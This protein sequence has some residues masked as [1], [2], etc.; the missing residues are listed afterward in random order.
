MFPLHGSQWDG[1]FS[2]LRR[3]A[4]VDMGIRTPRGIGCPKI[5]A[6]ALKGC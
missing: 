6:M 3:R 4:S 2:P 1:S 5:L